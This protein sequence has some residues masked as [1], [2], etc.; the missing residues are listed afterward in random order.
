MQDW[1]RAG[2]KVSHNSSSPACPPDCQTLL[3]TIRACLPSLPP[4]LEA[5]S[6]CQILTGPV[7]AAILG[8]SC[9]FRLPHCKRVIIC[10]NLIVSSISHRCLGIIKRERYSADLK[11]GPFFRVLP[12]TY[13]S[14]LLSLAVLQLPLHGQCRPVVKAEQRHLGAHVSV[15]LMASVS[16]EACRL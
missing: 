4:Q 16:E 15:P 14:L 11:L 5:G 2:G 6:S 9:P 13:F 3:I 8:C 1:S 10:L 12:T 7:E